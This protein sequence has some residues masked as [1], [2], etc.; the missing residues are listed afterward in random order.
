M[1]TKAAFSNRN[2]ITAFIFT[3]GVGLYLIIASFITGRN[4]FFL[5]LNRDLGKSADYFF[6]F[7]TNLGDGIIWI[8]VAVLFFIFQKNKLPL[9]IAAIIVSTLITQLTKNYIFPA[10]RRPTAAIQD[11]SLIHTVPGVELHTAYSFPSGHTATAFTIYLLASLFI[12]K[13]WIIPVGFVYALLVGYSR[14]Y[15]AQ[16]F[17]LDVGGGMITSLITILISI[18]IQQQWEKRKPQI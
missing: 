1:F 17:P 11:I 3:L 6:S 10:E 2:F 4:E 18:Y 5:M 16:H 9:L 14:I 12:R 13:R 15:L 8:V 7:W